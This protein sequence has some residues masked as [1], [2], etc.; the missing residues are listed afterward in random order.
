MRATESSAQHHWYERETEHFRIVYREGHAHLVTHI[1]RS[2]ETSLARLNELFHFVPSEKIVINTYD[3]NDYGGGYAT[4]V[5][6]NFI[7]LDLA[8]LEPGYE[9]IPYNERLQW[10]LSHELVHIVVNDLSTN[11]EALSRSVFSK[12]APE[13]VQPL[14]ILYSVL[15]NHSRYTPRWHQEGI[16]VFLETWMSGGFGRVLGSFDEMYF[17]S[18][19]GR[20]KPFPSSILL[21]TLVPNTSFLLE[22]N[23]Y[24]FGGRFATYLALNHGPDRLIQ[25]YTPHS[26]DFYTTFRRRFENVYRLSFE[27][28][29]AD[30]IR[31]ERDFQSL[32]LERLKSA[33]LTGI[34]RLTGKPAGAVTQAHFDAA[35]RALYWGEHHPHELAYIRR[36]DLLSRKS[37]EVSTLPTPSMYQVASTAYDA[38]K[39]TLFFTTNN[40]QLSRDIWMLDVKKEEKQLVFENCRVGH[41]TVSPVT[42]E[43]WGIRHTGGATVLVGSSFP[44]DS[45]KDF[46]QF[47]FGDEIHG[48]AVDPSGELLAAVLHK[49]DGEQAIVLFTCDKLR[50]GQAREYSVM[51]DIGSPENPSWDTQGRTLYWNA[52]TNGVSNIFRKSIDSLSA[53]PVS[54]TLY[55]LFKP[56]YLTK[57]SLFA[58]EFSSEGF[59]PVIIPNAAAGRLPAIKYLGQRVSDRFPEVTRWP[60]KPLAEVEEQSE[61]ASGNEYNGLAHLKLVS[62]FP[63]ISGFQSQKVIGLFAHVSDPILDHDFTIEAGVTPFGENVQRMRFHLKMKYEYQKA[64]EIGWG[65]NGPDFFDLFNTRKRAALGDRIRL[66]NT[67]YWVYDNPYKSKQLSEIVLYRNVTSVNDNIVKVSQ[68]DF[69]V[70]QTALNFQSLRRSIGSSDFES[71]NELN[72]TLMFFGSN[73]Q[74]PQT[75]VNVYGEWD[76][77]TT[78]IAPHNVFH[79]KLSAGYHQVNDRLL[80]SRFYFGGFGN[81]ALENVNVKQ[82]RKTFSFP[83]IPVFSFGSDRFAK[84]MLENNFPPI[85]FGDIAFGQ[86]HLSHVDASVFSEVLVSNSRRWFGAD[87][88]VQMNLVLKHWFNLESTLSAGVARAWVKRVPSF[89]WFV[90]YK[91]LKN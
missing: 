90:S 12:V 47:E 32:N 89:E 71:G 53:E 60:V 65:H 56:T 50:T 4:T 64:F 85:R 82:F 16:A 5:P 34:R 15:T 61:N 37:D 69:I 22:T 2:A 9:N 54:H 68:P 67:H 14:S 7:W 88:G 45:L 87:V 49:L 28:A 80:Q 26:K 57:D 3:V 78:A 59:Y 21:E 79:L 30:F 48:L 81:R 83:G 35:S 58:F 18:L 73:P 25:W 51:T 91:L 70:A 6:R 1:L 84:F 8:P 74:K 36:F 19:V 63:V 43:L 11:V 33:S 66:A 86:H 10:L 38:D 27:E 72:F 77:F 39:G 75:S 24:L 29:W 17:R 42:H 46:F 13:Q 31:Y 76:H 20:R 62:L 44:Y 55:G 52:Y 40:N 23:Y 41:L